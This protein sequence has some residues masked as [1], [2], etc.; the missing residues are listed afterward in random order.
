LPGTEPSTTLALQEISD[1]IVIVIRND[2]PM[3]T[4][5]PDLR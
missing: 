1:S 5:L 2:N 3:N 4:V